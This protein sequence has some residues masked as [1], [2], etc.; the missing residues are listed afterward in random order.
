LNKIKISIVNYTNTLPFKWAIK[1]SALFEKIELQ[2]DIPSICAQ[3]LKFKQVDLALIPVAV[4]SELDS[5]FIETD[6]CIGANGK[7]DS[8]KLYSQVPLDQID[9][10][11]L[12]YQS[13]S[14]ITL[15]KVLFKYF[16]KKNVVYVDAKP[17]FEKE[18]KDNNAA[19]VI[20]D[21]TFA[22]NGSYQFE[23]D[24]AEEWKKFTGLPFV[25]AAW[26][27]TEKLSDDFVKEFNEVLKQGINHITEAVE[28]DYRPSYLSKEYTIKYLTQRI[29]YQLDEDKRQALALF[30]DYIGEL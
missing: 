29:D 24:L 22:L 28:E 12:D 25:F 17:G 11:V 5:Y 14:S 26:V 4:L 16:W 15:T 19:V 13:R 23:Y 10:V 3:K 21:R 27:S 9:T 2:E 30:L 1:K 18:I 20:G 6:F 8:V 7:V